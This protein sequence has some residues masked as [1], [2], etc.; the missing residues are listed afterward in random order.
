MNQENDE[1]KKDVVVPLAPATIKVTAC[2]PTVWLSANLARLWFDDASREATTG[3]DENSM[4]REI[5]FSC[6]YL[7]SYIFEWVR[8]MDI[9]C[10][11]NY[12]PAEPRF[13]FKKDP[14]Y[15]RTPKKKW[16]EVPKELFDAGKIA[17]EP[18]L[19]LSK[20]GTLIK[21]RDGFIHAAASRPSTDSQRPKEKPV[22]DS[23]ELKRLKPGWALSIAI[24]LVKKLHLDL[25]T[26]APDY[27]QGWSKKS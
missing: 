10:V 17:C 20:L 23:D 21:Y 15:R 18:Q 7:E 6:C 24:E 1:E 26:K 13:R 27:L 25:G 16:K 5:V 22:P 11:N 14:R 4:R 2:A 9:G 12:F 8:N 3:N 19:N